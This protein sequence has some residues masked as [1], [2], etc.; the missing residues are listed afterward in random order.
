MDKCAEYGWTLANTPGVEKIKPKLLGMKGQEVDFDTLEVGDSGNDIRRKNSSGRPI[1]KNTNA[2]RRVDLAAAR[3]ISEKYVGSQAY[4]DGEASEEFIKLDLGD[5]QDFEA[6]NYNHRLRRKLRRAVEAGQIRKEM[7]V[8]E[9]VKELC[10]ESDLEPPLEL[11][12]SAKAVHERGQR[13]LDSGQIET[14]K[15]ERVRFRIE[16]AEF[17]KAAKVLRK[18]A[19][20]IALEAGLRVHA[21][22]TGRLPPKSYAINE[23]MSN[24]YGLGWH[25]PPKANPKDL[26]RPEDVSVTP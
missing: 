22:M 19:K 8:R 25:L 24:K 3:N 21:E 17:N 6:L 15:A 1:S 18:Q 16:L 20:E 12:T 9:R 23:E 2:T 4:A 7:L 5:G 10:I 14:N 11:S 26:I 13:V